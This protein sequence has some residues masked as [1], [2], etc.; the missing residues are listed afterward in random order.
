MGGF[1]PILG[2]NVA[3]GEARTGAGASGPGSLRLRI[4]AQLPADLAEHPE[5]EASV[6]C[7]EM[8]ATNEAAKLFL[9]ERRGACREI[10]AGLKDFEEMLSQALYVSRRCSELAWGGGS[11]SRR[12]DDFMKT[13]GDGLAEI[14]GPVGFAGG[15]AQQPVAM[16]EVCIGEADFFGAEQKR[17][18]AGSEPFAQTWRRLVET[19]QRVVELATAGCGGADNEHAIGDGFCDGSEFT[20]GGEDG[21]STDGGASF[22][23]RGRVRMDDAEVGESKIGH[24]TGGSADVEG[25]ARGYED[26]AEAI[27]VSCATHGAQVDFSGCPGCHTSG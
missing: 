14:H 19:P 21:R 9:R 23:E 24:C 6:G 7:A 10:R 27:Q 22:A 18:T 20:G 11:G 5:E 8:Q 25:I 26:D 13:D 1:Y 4:V 2:G 15:N 3:M 12:A 16:T 17:Y